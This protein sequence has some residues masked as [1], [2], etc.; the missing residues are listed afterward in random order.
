[1]PVT[2]PVRRRCAG[3]GTDAAGNA[4]DRRRHLRRLAQ[5]D[6]SACVVAERESVSAAAG[7]ALGVDDPFDAVNRYPEFLPERLRGVIADRIGVPADQVV[8]GCGRD[9]RRDAGAAGTDPPGDTDGDGAPTF[10]GYPILARMAR[11]KTLGSRST[12]TVITTWTGSPAP[13]LRPAWWCCA[14]RTT[15]PERWSRGCGFGVPAPVPRNTIVLLDEAYIEFAAPEH[16]IDVSALFVR[17]PMSSWSNLLQGVRPG[18]A[19]HRLRGGVAGAGPDAV[20]AC[21][22]RSA[23]RSPLARG[24]G[25]IRRGRATSATV[26]AD[27]RGTMRSP[28]A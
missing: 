5:G 6:R 15:P 17:F 22:C 7:G 25:V 14:G 11:L 27:Q 13:P 4:P 26:P 23:S 10:D 24:R 9:G 19:A 21:S 2:S 18:G 20:V 1:M 12:S 3:A 8:L 28:V 16:R